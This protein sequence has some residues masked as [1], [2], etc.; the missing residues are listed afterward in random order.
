MI[1]GVRLPKRERVKSE[2]VP[3][4]TL[5]IRATTEPAALIVPSI[6]SL[7]LALMFSSTAGKITEVKATQ[8]IAQATA[9]KVKPML[10]RM[11]L[12]RFVLD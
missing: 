1:H 7:P 12:I 2:K 6:D 11:S 3:K 5:A 8:G 10:K 4:T 9:L